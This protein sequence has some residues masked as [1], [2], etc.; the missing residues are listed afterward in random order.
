MSYLGDE[1]ALAS[2]VP[3]LSPEPVLRQD[4]VGLCGSWC[5][6]NYGR[7][8]TT[9]PH[10][11]PL[12]TSRNHFSSPHQPKRW[13]TTPFPLRS[14]NCRQVH[15]EVF[16]CW[17]IFPAP[18]PWFVPFLFRSLT[19]ASRKIRPHRN[20]EGLSAEAAK[21][22]RSYFHFRNPES[23]EVGSAGKEHKHQTTFG[24]RQ[25]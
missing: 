14:P 13:S 5:T 11:I 21:D 22:L 10:A 12:Y 23:I 18:C 17:P 19:Q 16:H 24:W 20:F 15:T 1:K 7:Q 3:R 4:P 6:T 8:H 2:Y 25:K 9:P